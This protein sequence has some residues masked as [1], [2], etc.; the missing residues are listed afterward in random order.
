[1]CTR[2]CNVISVVPFHLMAACVLSFDG[3]LDGTLFDQ[4]NGQ[5]WH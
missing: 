1:M 5:P 4:C 2:V 3:I